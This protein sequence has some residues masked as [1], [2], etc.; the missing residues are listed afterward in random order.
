MDSSKL[1]HQRQFQDTCAV[2]ALNNAVGLPVISISQARNKAEELNQAQQTDQHKKGGISIAAILATLQQQH[3][4]KYVLRRVKQITERTAP[5]FLC[6]QSTGRFMAL[7]W[8][9]SSGQYHWVAVL[10]EKRLVID[11]AL[12]KPYSI[13]KLHCGKNISRVYEIVEA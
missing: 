9:K 11:G 8:K 1:L 13:Q 4:R 6:K 12:K 3:G 5:L 7:E 10:C 2:Q